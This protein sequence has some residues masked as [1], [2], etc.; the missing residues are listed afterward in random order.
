MNERIFV[1]IARMAV[2]K[3]PA[4][5]EAHALGS[6]LGVALFDNRSKIG[7]LL[8]AMLPNSDSAMSSARSNSAKFV[9]VG[10]EEMLSRMIKEGAVRKNVTAKLAG[11]ANMFPDIEF[12]N[13]SIGE[14]N[15]ESALRKLE[16]IGI[17]VVAQ[18]VGSNYGRTML[19]DLN[20]GFVLVKSIAHGEKHL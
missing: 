13:M 19:F 14:R 10:I 5:L 9:D 16:N 4:V 12:S 1:G 20:S 11:C 8:H 17:E 15:L 7:G 3:A 18:D 2:A 6:C